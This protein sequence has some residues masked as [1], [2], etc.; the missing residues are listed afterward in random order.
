MLRLHCSR[1]DLAGLRDHC[2]QRLPPPRVADLRDGRLVL[3]RAGHA[4][5]A[6]RVAAPPDEAAVERA[7][8]A[9][10]LDQGLAASLQEKQ[11]FLVS[12]SC[13]CPEP[14]LVK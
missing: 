4:L 5:S 3:R 10:G 7:D 9:A 1:L 14:V 13:V 2:L 8:G 11:Y 12:F 6:V